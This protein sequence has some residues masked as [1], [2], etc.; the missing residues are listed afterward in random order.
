MLLSLPFNYRTVGQQQQQQES[1][2]SSK[3][4]VGVVAIITSAAVRV[5]AAAE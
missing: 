2:L 4:Q 5:Y 3:L 1:S